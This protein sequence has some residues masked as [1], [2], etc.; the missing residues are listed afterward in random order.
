[1][2]KWNRKSEREQQRHEHRERRPD[3]NCNR[4][5]DSTRR[6]AIVGSPCVL[7]AMNRS[8]TRAK[9]KSGAYAAASQ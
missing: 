2:S 6:S 3:T 1:M 5:Q 4:G 8:W 9:E 7:V